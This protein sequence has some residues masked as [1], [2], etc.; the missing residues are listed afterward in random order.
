MC[1]L[2]SHPTSSEK[3]VAVSAKFM[4]ERGNATV[5]LGPEYT[6]SWD[7]SAWKGPLKSSDPTFHGRGSLEWDDPVLNSIL[8]TSSDEDSTTS[9]GRLFRSISSLRGL[10]HPLFLPGARTC[11][12][13]SL[14]LPVGQGHGGSLTC[15]PTRTNISIFQ[16]AGKGCS[17]CQSCGE[18][19]LWSL[20]KAPPSY[21]PGKCRACLVAS[22]QT[23]HR[24]WLCESH[25]AGSPAGRSV[26][27]GKCLL[28]LSAV[29]EVY[30]LLNKVMFPMQMNAL[31]NGDML[32]RFMLNMYAL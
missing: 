30:V 11:Q 20:E 19:E 6:E 13:L 7:S 3:D 1:S 24:Q 10:N 29:Q 4:Q 9:L 5:F 22:G 2:H 26:H 15:W 25:R 27:L 28:F 16:Q 32:T 17:G 8:K 12:D 31:W 23:S 21:Y 14:L 18:P